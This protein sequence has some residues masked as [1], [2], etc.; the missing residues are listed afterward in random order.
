[1][2]FFKTLRDHR[3][4]L[5]LTQ[6]TVCKTIDVPPDRYIRLEKGKTRPTYD[7]A[8][9]IAACLGVDADLIFPVAPPVVDVDAEPQAKAS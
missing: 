7:E 4:A 5:G 9:R 1:L 8:L 2:F 6:W 3:D